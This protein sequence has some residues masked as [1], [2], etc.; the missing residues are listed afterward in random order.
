[1]PADAGV[2]DEVAGD[3]LAVS[4]RTVAVPAT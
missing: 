2:V 3:D 1:M 4:V